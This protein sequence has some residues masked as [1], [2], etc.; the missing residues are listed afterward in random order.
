MD[1]EEFKNWITEEI[2]KFVSED[3]GNRLKQL[4]GSP[5]FEEPLV[6]FVAGND[7]YSANL[8]RLL[9]SSTLLHTRL[10]QK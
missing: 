4:D 8:K 9:G 2:K 10:W 1:V 6:G 5:I 7:P 3:P